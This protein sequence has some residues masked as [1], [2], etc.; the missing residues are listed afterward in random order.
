MAKKYTFSILLALLLTSCGGG[1]GGGGGG[2]D[3]APPL[4]MIT[5]NST[6]LSVLIGSTVTISWSVTNASSCTATGAW[7]GTKSLSGTEDAIINTPGNNTFTLT[8]QGSGGGNS[9]SVVVEGYRNTDGVVV[10]GYISSA[11]VFV[12]EDEDWMADTNESSTTSDNNGKFTIK[13]ADGYLVSL[14]Q[15]FNHSQINR[16]YGFQSGYSGNLGGCFYGN[17]S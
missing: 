10:D 3:A 7:S 9:K 5:I 15:S 11:E 1:G 14:G 17:P 12:D 16:S 8:C 6:S 13:Y 2:A 4:P